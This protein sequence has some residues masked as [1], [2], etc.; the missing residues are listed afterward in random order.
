MRA[1]LVSLSVSLIASSA[2]ADRQYFFVY[3]GGDIT[4]PADAGDDV[5]FRPTI[6]ND[7]DPAYNLTYVPTGGGLFWIDTEAIPADNLP[8][9]LYVD[10]VAQLT[11]Q[12]QVGNLI[13]NDKVF[14]NALQDDAVTPDK[15]DEDATFVLEPLAAAPG[16]SFDLTANNGVGARGLQVSYGT[17]A[18]QSGIL[19][20]GIG[21][22]ISQ[23]GMSF[24]MQGGN[25]ADGV[26][27]NNQITANDSKGLWVTTANYG[28][29]GTTYSIRAHGLG[30][31]AQAIY[32]KGEGDDGVHTLQ[33]IYSGF[34][35]NV[36]AVRGE[37]QGGGIGGWFY[38]QDASPAVK[39]QGG[40]GQSDSLMVWEGVGSNY[41]LIDEI[42]TGDGYFYQNEASPDVDPRIIGGP[43]RLPVGE[44]RGCPRDRELLDGPKRLRPSGHDR[45]R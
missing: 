8:V 7:G 39:I 32:A 6:D 45:L 18:G 10:G 41:I 5:E 34:E 38:G 29:S 20:S 22:G 28:A 15:L 21:N 1:F 27:I 33:S 13:G 35:Y 26:I 44:R 24:S 25:N 14:T 43:S 37:T 9:D 4:N 16:L 36:A 30:D 31:R 19:L 42:Y 3:E 12:I 40:D 11:T 17:A 23:T 2:L